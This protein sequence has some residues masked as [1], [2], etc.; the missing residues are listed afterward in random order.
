MGLET[1]V[2]LRELGG[3]AGQNGTPGADGLSEQLYCDATDRTG[4]LIPCVW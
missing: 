2:W 3:S 4:A 1:W